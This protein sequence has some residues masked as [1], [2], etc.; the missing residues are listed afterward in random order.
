MIYSVFAA[1]AFN[2]HGTAANNLQWVWW[3]CAVWSTELRL[4]LCKVLEHRSTRCV[5]VWHQND[6]NNSR[7]ASNQ[8]MIFHV[9]AAND[10][11]NLWDMFRFSVK[12]ANRV[13]LLRLRLR[14][15]SDGGLC[16]HFWI[17]FQNNIRVVDGMPSTDKQ[18]RLRHLENRGCE[19]VRQS[20]HWLAVLSSQT[21]HSWSN[22]VSI[23]YTSGE[24]MKLI[25]CFERIHSN[26]HSWMQVFNIHVFQLN[27]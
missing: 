14:H 22:F 7:Q 3:L 27:S 23:S 9:G 6:D 2:V 24:E 5:A 13:F 16:G 26:E 11:S 15:Q 8:Q 18:T 21:H 10:F 1:L 12:Y 4:V 17:D 20:G 19:L 25:L